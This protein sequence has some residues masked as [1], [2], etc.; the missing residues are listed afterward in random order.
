VVQ[1]ATLEIVVIFRGRFLL[2][3]RESEK[4][5]GGDE[6]RLAL[7]RN[8]EGKGAGRLFWLMRELHKDA[9]PPQTGILLS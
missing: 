6:V 7:K 9:Q 1:P 5:K 8:S 3:E 2:G 4:G